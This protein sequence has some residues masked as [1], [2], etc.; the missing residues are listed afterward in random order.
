MNVA[1]IGS[2]EGFDHFKVMS[3]LYDILK[4]VDVDNIISGGARGIDK[5]AESF[6]D[7]N[8]INKIIVRPD[9]PSNKFDYIKRNW[10]IVD[11]SDIIIAFWDGKSKGTKSVIDYCEKKNSRII[12]IQK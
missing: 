10:K 3:K 9:N 4:D 12:V 2:R 5:C 8:N 11:M 1:I 7:E 6:A